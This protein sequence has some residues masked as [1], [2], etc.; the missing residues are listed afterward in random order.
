MTAEIVIPPQVRA[1]RALLGWS[2][3]DLA[4]KAGVAITT[5]RDVEAEKRSETAAAGEVVRALQN[6]GV[7]FVSGSTTSGPGVRLAK[8]RPNV[9]RR[10]QAM[11]A[12]DGLPVDIEFQGQR[13][14]A[15]VTI[16]I[17][18]DLA[19]IDAESHP[20]L[21]DYLR[22]FDHYR[23][24]ILDGIRVAFERGVTW[25]R[26]HQQLRVR[27]IDIRDLV[28]DDEW[29]RLVTTN[30]KV[31]GGMPV[32]AG[33]RVPIEIALSSLE[34]GVDLEELK[35]SYPFLTPAHLDAARAYEQEHPRAKSPAAGSRAPSAWKAKSRRVTRRA[36]KE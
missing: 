27:A 29:G 16:E 9:I 26:D 34:A 12:W 8:S 2:Q 4:R 22:I 24:A 21:Q 1:G 33:S 31:M 7:E 30:P 28:P 35:L 10:P 20:S 32:F 5:V 17:L 3:E 11:S 25:S 13:F 23:G 18:E 15:F 6:G 14:T 36:P 19:E